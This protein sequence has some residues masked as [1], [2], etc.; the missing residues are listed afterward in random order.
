MRLARFV[1]WL[2]IAVVL[3]LLS[4]APVDARLFAG[5]C[6]CGDCPLAY[7]EHCTDNIPVA[8]CTSRGCCRFV[9]FVGGVQECS[10]VPECQEEQAPLT[11]AAPALGP[12]GVA[13]AVVAATAIGFGALRRRRG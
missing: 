6:V 2:P 11:S 5:C 10:S 12:V 4:V 8:E 3:L 13:L 1:P 9:G 7:P